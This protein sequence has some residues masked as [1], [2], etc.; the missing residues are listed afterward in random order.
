[1]VVAA[2]PGAPVPVPAAVASDEGLKEELETVKAELAALR[3]E[4][5]AFK[6]QF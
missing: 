2:A 3:A 4:F 5:E 6:A 1:M